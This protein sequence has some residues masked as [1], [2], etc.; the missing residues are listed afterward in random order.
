MGPI[1]EKRLREFEFA[2]R[3]DAV[4]RQ[5]TSGEHE[6]VAQL[7][8]P[9][10]VELGTDPGGDKRVRDVFARPVDGGRDQGDAADI[11]ALIDSEAGLFRRLDAL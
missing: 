2:R 6:R 11:V 4:N 10:R 5:R 9:F 8:R 3:S 1:A 7:H